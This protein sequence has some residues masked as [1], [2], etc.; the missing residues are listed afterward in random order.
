MTF[1]E[2]K[3]EARKLGYKIVKDR[4]TIKLLP[5]NCGEKNSVY[6]DYTDDWQRYFRCKRCGFMGYFHR[7]TYGAR[8]EWNRA[9]GKNGD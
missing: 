1:E 4:P 7:K 6:M 3:A 8:E 9:V 2:L 5:C